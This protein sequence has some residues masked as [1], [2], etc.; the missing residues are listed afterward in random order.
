MKFHSFFNRAS[1]KSGY[2]LALLSLSACAHPSS[3]PQATQQETA[4]VVES[5]DSTPSSVEAEKSKGDS[6]SQNEGS[7]EEGSTGIE[8]TDAKG[9]EERVRE[10]GG[11]LPLPLPV[12]TDRAS[13]TGAG[14]AEK[15]SSSFELP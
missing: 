13:K 15:T 12:K 11:S 7:G 4:T 6:S 2:G 14:G 3:T 1:T 5:S 9:P 10:R 8:S